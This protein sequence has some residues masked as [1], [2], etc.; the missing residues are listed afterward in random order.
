MSNNTQR[1]RVSRASWGSAG[2][3]ASPFVFISFLQVSVERKDP[4]F[5]WLVHN[6]FDRRSSRGFSRLL[7]TSFR[8][9]FGEERKLPPGAKIDVDIGSK[10][11]RRDREK[12]LS[13]SH[14]I[15]YA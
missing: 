12:M 9:R 8:G 4:L 3:A 11:V 1:Q 10:G 15:L 5:D 7:F 2:N 13:R 14:S 6:F